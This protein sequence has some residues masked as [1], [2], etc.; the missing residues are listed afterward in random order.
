MLRQNLGSACWS[1][2]EC[3]R[4]GGDIDLS[5]LENLVTATIAKR[6]EI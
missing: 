4:T 2:P 6:T 5:L 3:R 1:Y